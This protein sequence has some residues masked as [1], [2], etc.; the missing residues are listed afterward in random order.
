KARSSAAHSRDG[1]SRGRAAPRK[2]GGKLSATLARPANE[3]MATR[4]SGTSERFPD[5]SARPRLALKIANPA[6]TTLFHPTPTATALP[7]AACRIA[8]R[9]HRRPVTMRPYNNRA[10]GFRVG[11]HHR[12]WSGV[13][14]CGRFHPGV[15][16]KASA[17]EVDRRL[18]VLAIAEA[19]G[20]FFYHLDLAV[21]SFGRRIGH[22]MLEIG[23]DVGQ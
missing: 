18:I 20:H 19:T 22:V 16:I 21:Q 17:M 13:R 14:S 12:L 5:G 9:A 7:H 15:E 3:R 10:S 11:D 8:A 4:H 1:P 2:L 23:Q 6:L